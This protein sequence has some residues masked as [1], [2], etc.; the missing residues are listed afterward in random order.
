MASNFEII[1][2]GLGVKASGFEIDKSTIADTWKDRKKI[3]SHVFASDN[4]SFSKKRCIVR[5]A[6]YEELD[7]ARYIW[8]TQQCVKGNPVSGPL[9][10]EK[11]LQMF[12]TLNPAKIKN[13]SQLALFDMA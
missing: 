2:A 5:E 10:Q 3:K 9:L 13:C 12:S 6:Q 11:A 7:R 1:S 4:P 8:F